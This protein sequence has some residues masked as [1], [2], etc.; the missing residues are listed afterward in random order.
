MAGRQNYAAALLKKAISH[1]RIL[2]SIPANGLFKGDAKDF[3]TFYRQ[4]AQMMIKA[5]GYSGQFG[6]GI[7]RKRI[8]EILP[9]N[10]PAIAHHIIHQQVQPIG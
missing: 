5:P 7:G 6:I 3:K 1:F 2:Y 4:I 8:P 10:T 9:N